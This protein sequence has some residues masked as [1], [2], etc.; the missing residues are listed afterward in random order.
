MS[1]DELA[2][3]LLGLIW[4]STK[5]NHAVKSLR[6]SDDALELALSLERAH[7]AIAE[8]VQKLFEITQKRDQKLFQETEEKAP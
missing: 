8:A 1:E 7:G 3:I 5:I 4:A 6:E 2:N